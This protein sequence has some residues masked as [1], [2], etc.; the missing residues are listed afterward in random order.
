ME[1]TASVG[2]E[3]GLVFSTIE[4]SASVAE[5]VL[6]KAACWID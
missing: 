2:H 1:A 3:K 6:H 5:Q 4:S